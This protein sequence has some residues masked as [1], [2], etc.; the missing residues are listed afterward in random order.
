MAI[1]IVAV[2]EPIWS[3]TTFKV[4]FALVAFL[5]LISPI[6]LFF[7]KEVY[8]PVKFS[9]KYIF[10]KNHLKNFF[11][12]FVEGI[13]N[14]TETVIWVVF[15]F[16]MLK[17]FIS[18]GILATLLILFTTFMTFIVGRLSDVMKKRKIMKIGI[19]SV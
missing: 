5:V 6:S 2:G 13:L 11:V 18:L 14:Y 7:S 3:S 8:T 10:H 12:F 17:S 1:S 4:L 19:F 9:I 15:I 16:L